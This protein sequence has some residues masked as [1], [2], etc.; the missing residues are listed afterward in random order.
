MKNGA[1]I[2][3]AKYINSWKYGIPFVMTYINFPG[4]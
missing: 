4:D 1:S 3:Q 2:R